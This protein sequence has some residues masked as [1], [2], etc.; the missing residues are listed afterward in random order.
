MGDWTQTEFTELVHS[1]GSALI[2]YARQWTQAAE[3]VVQESFLRL[4]AQP[5]RPRQTV[6][7]LYTTVR[8]AALNH[9]RGEARRRN[10]ERQHALASNPWFEY[11]PASRLDATTVTEALQ[12]LPNRQREVVIARLWGTLTFAQIAQLVGVS[13]A[14]AQREYERG[15]QT[16]RKRLKTSKVPAASRPTEPKS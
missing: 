2:L 15:L 5:Q 14:T 3:D 11:E 12:S 16:L 13:V 10:H 8:H 7:W 1:H 9:Q 6:A 4:L